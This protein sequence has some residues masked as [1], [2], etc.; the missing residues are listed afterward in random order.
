MNKDI[1]EILYYLYNVDP[2]FNFYV[3]SFLKNN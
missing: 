3:K 1:K 2:F